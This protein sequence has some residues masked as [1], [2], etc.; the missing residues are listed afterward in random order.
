[1][2]R[3]RKSDHEKWIP[4]NVRESVTEPWLSFENAIRH[5]M[6]LAKKIR[7]F[8]FDSGVLAVYVVA[9]ALIVKWTVRRLT[10]GTATATLLVKPG[11]IMINHQQ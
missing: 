4:A 1:M 8:L 5:F 10:R 3:G 9:G 11:R 2:L 7:V 6:L